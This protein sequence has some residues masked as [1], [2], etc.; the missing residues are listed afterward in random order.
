MEDQSPPHPFF[1]WELKEIR[2]GVTVKSL[3]G[4]TQAADADAAEKQVRDVHNAADK[5]IFKVTVTG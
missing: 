1:R 3:E 5:A 4:T 2:D